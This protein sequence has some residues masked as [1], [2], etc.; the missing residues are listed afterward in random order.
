[1]SMI[2]VIVIIGVGLGVFALARPVLTS[3][4]DAM[5]FMAAYPL[6]TIGTI[7]V[8]ATVVMYLLGVT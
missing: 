1:M 7:L 8:V 4:F 3:I 2:T 5:R 6:V